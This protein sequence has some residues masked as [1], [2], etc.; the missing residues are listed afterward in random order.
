MSI[1]KHRIHIVGAAAASLLAATAVSTSVAQAGLGQL[2]GMNPLS[3]AAMGS[4]LAANSHLSG[5]G[6]GDPSAGRPGASAAGKESAMRF[7]Y[8]QI[9][10]MRFKYNQIG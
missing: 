2:R 3:R 6:H 9:T 5:G 4:G 8:D 10:H 1:V 7:K